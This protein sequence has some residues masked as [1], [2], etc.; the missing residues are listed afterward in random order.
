[1]SEEDKE[2]FSQVLCDSLFEVLERGQISARAQDLLLTPNIEY[3]DSIHAVMFS[4]GVSEFVYGYEK[5]NLGDLGVHLGRRIRARANQLA[6]GKFHCDPPKYGFG[7]RSSGHR[8]IP[9]KSAVIRSIFLIRNC[10]RCA[11]CK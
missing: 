2:K 1:M 3:K 4:G 10:C 8:N 9:C 5:R 7:R 11:T 6:G